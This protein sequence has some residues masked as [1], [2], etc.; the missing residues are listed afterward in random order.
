M[1]EGLRKLGLNE[2]E[3]KAYS[4]L[5]KMGVAPAVAVAKHSAIPRAR[6]YDV[7]FS[8][9]KKGFVVKSASKPVEFSPI[10]PKRAFHSI[11]SRKRAEL[12]AH[13][14]E[15]EK[16]ALEV[17]ALAGQNTGFDFE[18]AWV[19]EGRDSIYSMIAEQL[20]KCK[21]SVLISSDKDGISRKKA[22]FER[23][24]SDLSRRGVRVVAKAV[25]GGRFVVFD[26]DSVLLFL[27]PHDSVPEHDRAIFVKSPFAARYFNSSIQK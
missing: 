25:E 10:K 1:H 12:D 21:E 27:S 2:Y 20:E 17:E 13:L 14:Q 15:L 16:S 22:I 5:L 4:S 6:V 26:N 23:N 19:L 7:L 11:A 3:S 8:L 18:S 24:L 9:E